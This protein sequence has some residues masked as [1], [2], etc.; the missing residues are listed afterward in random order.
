MIGQ[1]MIQSIVD[2]SYFKHGQKR[3]EKQAI[4]QTE[5]ID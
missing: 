2:Y 1:I 5:N 4:G 3:G